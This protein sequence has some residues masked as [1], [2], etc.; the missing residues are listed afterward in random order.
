M[1]H[2]LTLI[3]FYKGNKLKCENILTK[4]DIVSFSVN[5]PSSDSSKANKTNRITSTVLNSHLHLE[6]LM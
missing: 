6:N 5:Y 1:I 2:K 3:K 4:C